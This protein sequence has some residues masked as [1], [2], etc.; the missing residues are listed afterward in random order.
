MITI[1]DVEYA[2]EDLTEEA[3]ARVERI[4]ELQ[5]QVHQTLLNYEELQAAMSHHA[6]KIKEALNVPV[7]SD[8]AN[9]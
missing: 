6:A 9:D 2:E 8:E 5:K 4:Q 1:D 7:Q 3:K